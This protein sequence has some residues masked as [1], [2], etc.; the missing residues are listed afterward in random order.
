MVRFASIAVSLAVVS[1]TL[2]AF[3]PSPTPAPN[4]V[5]TLNRRGVLDWLGLGDDDNSTSTAP[6]WV[7]Q[8]PE[9]EMDSYAAGGF[10]E[11]VVEAREAQANGTQ[12][13]SDCY[14]TTTVQERCYGTNGTM[15]LCACESS[16]LK[17]TKSCASCLGGNRPEMASN[18]TSFC[19]RHNYTS[20]DGDNAA[21]SRLSQSSFLAQG[22]LAT[23]LVA[24]GF[25]LLA[26]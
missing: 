11:I 20:S 12:C 2:A 25:A 24:A 4:L 21:S 6:I 7:D 8:T 10:A 19:D 18:W 16:Q 13:A 15:V 5:R 1:T 9:E 26:L 3:P 22:G 23:V 14:D 17:S